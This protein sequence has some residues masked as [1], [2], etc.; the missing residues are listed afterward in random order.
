M[1]TMK[2]KDVF[3]DRSAVL[4]RL[5]AARV[6]VLSKQGAFVRTAARTS[7]RKRK[8]TSSPGNPPFSH[9]GSLRRLILFG[10]E[11]SSESVIVGP[12]GFEGSD[13]PA[14]L[15]HGGPSTR[16]FW[17]KKNGRL[18]KKRVQIR[19]RP[20]MLPALEREKSKMPDLFKDALTR[21]AP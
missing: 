18:A 4:D 6:K 12:V 10:Y 17:S 7:I 16:T 15:E 19:P 3:F 21:G 1:I 9:E 2:I 5:D 13:T 11:G 14:A 8:G 20:F